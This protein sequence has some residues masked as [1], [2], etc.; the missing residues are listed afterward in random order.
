[1]G[2]LATN[3]GSERVR[4]SLGSL[5]VSVALALG[6]TLSL[7]AISYADENGISFWLPGIYGS[8]AAVPQNP[9]WSVTAVNFFDSVS[10]SG[11]VAASREITIG[12]L[13]P[14]VNVNLNVNVKATLDLVLINA[15][16]VFA[17]PVFGGQL[18]LGMFGLVGPNSTALNGSLTLASGPFT[19][20]RQGTIS[21]TTTSFGDLYPQAIIRWNNGVH[22]WMVYG[23]GDIPVGDYSSSNLANIGIGH[24]AVDG[25][26]GYTYFDPKLGHEFS[27]V[28]G[29]T[30]NLINPSTDYQS[31]IDWHLDW[32]ASQFL[33]KQF[34]V[35]A[36]GYF[37]EQ[38]SPDSGSGDHLGPF[39]SG[40]IGVGPQVG[41]IL[42][43]G[44]V[45]AY[46]NL[47]AYGEFAGHDRPTGW[48]AWLT[49]S[50]SPLGPTNPKSAMLT[51]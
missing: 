10:A 12:K 44:Q 26:G 36:V 34:F 19:I 6:S 14:T 45:Q 46:L 11:N 29:F 9:G 25:G 4:S 38:V 51:K 15:G 37:Y 18:N 23:T 33:T 40:V 22:N 21:Q 7:P 43:V 30:Y 13:S 28:T 50:L 5:V 42:P 47:K 39:E 17:T 49:L 2:N 31:G 35:G 27:A 1:M 48:N 3:E 16:Y 24:G 41:Y 8:L 20:T 32:G